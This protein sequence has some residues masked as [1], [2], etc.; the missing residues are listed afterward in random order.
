M[1][2]PNFNEKGNLVGYYMSVND[3]FP[4]NEVKANGKYVAKYI[5]GMTMTVLPMT[6]DGTI[7]V[8][9]FNEE[10]ISQGGVWVKVTDNQ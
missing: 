9:T 1:I 10:P 3:E 7:E 5:T 6:E 2:R 8:R 4:K